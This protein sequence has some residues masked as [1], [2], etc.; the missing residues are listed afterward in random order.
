[1]THQHEPIDFVVTWVDDRDELWRA[2]REKY[3][4][5]KSKT[6]NM[7][8]RYRDW[9][10]LKFWFRGVEQNA[11]WVR[12]VY[13]VTDQQKPQ[14]LNLEHPKLK[15]VNHTDFIPQE[16]LPVFNSN[17]IEWNLHRIPGL[18]DRFV[19]FNDDMFLIDKV[20]PTD[21]FVK[22][23][24]C[25]LPKV[26][27]LFALDLFEF[28]LFNNMG[29]LNQN[30]SFKDSVKQN[31]GKWIK[32]NSPMD[33]MKLLVY[34]RNPHV[35]FIKSYHLHISYL[36]KTFEEMWEK[37]PEALHDTCTHKFRTKQDLTTWCVRDWQLLSGNFHPAKPIGKMFHTWGMKYDDSLL[38]YLKGKKG[39]V[40][41]LNDS[42]GED[43]FE[44]HKEALYKA[45]N[46]LFPEKSAFEI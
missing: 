40:I 13:F 25:D 21:F 30:F 35:P 37:E 11:P 27:M 38:T 12:H 10:L 6:G 45:M 34:C 33:I 26:G 4:S 29:L 18:S 19:Y 14:W 3:A 15:W 42:D 17:V 16:Y 24:P 41:C 28:M 39:K 2:K 46:Q 1:M 43:E 8:I 9:D 5:P 44:A 20:Q 7:D 22:G 32:K 23:L 36:K 31:L